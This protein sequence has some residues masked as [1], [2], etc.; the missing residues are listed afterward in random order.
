MHYLC[1]RFRKKESMSIFKNIMY[2]IL[3]P[4]VGWEEINQS[5][6]PTG[7]VLTSA[8]IPLLFVLALS[9][10]VPMLYDPTTTVKESLMNGIVSFFSYLLTYYITSYLL[11]GFYPELVKTSGSTARLNDFIVY[12]LILLVLLNII[13]NLLPSDFTPALFLMLYVPWVAYRGMDHLGVRK[14]KVLKFVVIASALI[15]LTPLLLM[16]LMDFFN[17]NT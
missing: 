3:H 4:R 15:M 10:F 12:N 14:E 7:K 13:R 9:C 17:I 2:V 6:I 1:T 11:G 16:Y 5:R 8:Y